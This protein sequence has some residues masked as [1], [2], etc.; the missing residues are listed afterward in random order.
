MIKEDRWQ[1]YEFIALDR[2]VSELEKIHFLS[3]SLLLSFLVHHFS[4]LYSLF[5]L[6]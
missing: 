3:F 5:G 4:N 6:F 2:E 1:G